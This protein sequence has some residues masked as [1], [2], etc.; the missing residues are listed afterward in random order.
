[1]GEEVPR[2][3]YAHPAPPVRVEQMLISRDDACV[4]SP[5]APHELVV[6]RV[7]RHRCGVDR[8]AQKPRLRYQRVKH[9]SVVRRGVGLRRSGADSPV[10]SRIEGV[11]TTSS[12]PSAHA[13]RSAR[14][15]PPKKWP[16]NHD[17]GVQDRPR[18]SWRRL[19]PRPA[20]A[21]SSS[22][23]GASTV[24]RVTTFPSPTTTNWS[25]GSRPNGLRIS[26]WDDDLTTRRQLRR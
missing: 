22:G 10:F 2:R 13:L 14:G 6:V 12:S 15:G 11:V 9:T 8:V 24:F 18:P 3:E 17:V 21:L 16:E 4:R 1:M 20:K 25:P 19:G 23:F 26:F 5:G 7:H